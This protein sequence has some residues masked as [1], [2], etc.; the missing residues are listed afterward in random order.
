MS[1]FQRSNRVVVKFHGPDAEKLLNDVLT[2]ELAAESGDARWWALLSP[3]GKVQAEGL[4]RWVEEGFILDVD[5]L[6]A[7]DFIKRMTLYRLRAKVE[8]SDLRES[9]G[10]GWTDDATAPGA[11][12]DPRQEDLGYH[13]LAPIDA[14]AD[15]E[16]QDGYLSRRIASGIAE[17]GTDF[18]VNSLFP[19]DVGMDLLSG[20]DFAKGCYV[21]QEV[22]SRMQHRGSARR[23]PVI[24][25]GA[26][27][28]T[29]ATLMAGDR[30]IGT[31]GLVAGGKAVGIVRIDKVTDL[32]AVHVDGVPVDLALPDWASYD[33]ADSSAPA[34]E[35]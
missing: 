9:H 6:S 19:H 29:G 34:D 14:C 25:S 18:G 3:Q 12:R 35:N 24:V 4:A 1:V 10:L 21:G 16:Q 15:W 22:V 5:A 7:D 33:F 8:I 11:V 13:V 17:V 31:A 2:A 20:V 23:R 28:E 32:G 26:A 27:L 30:E